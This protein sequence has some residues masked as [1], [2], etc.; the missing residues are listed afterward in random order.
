MVGIFL[1]K[2]RRVRYTRGGVIAEFAPALFVLLMVF[3]FPFL[4][5]LGL[6]L[7]YADCLYLDFLLMRQAALEN[8]LI[9]DNSTTPPG[10]KADLTCSTD[11]NGTLNRIIQAWL[12]NGL[13]KF[14]STGKVPVQTVYIDLTEGTP[15]VKYIHLNLAVE[16]RPFLQIPFPLKVP[17]LNA[18]VTF[19][20]TGRSV[21]ENIPN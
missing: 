14:A 21:I 7:S 1:M 4:N 19:N 10:Y 16:V 6:A 13:G 2:R 5:M 3:F 11:P 18:P 15:K 17:G 12:N 9:V 20:Y 8:V